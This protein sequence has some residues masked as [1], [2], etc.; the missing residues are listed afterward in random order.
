MSNLFYSRPCHLSPHSSA[1]HY[2]LGST[3]SFPSPNPPRPRP[4]HLEVP[5]YG[6]WWT[7]EAMGRVSSL[8]QAPIILAVSKP[9]KTILLRLLCGMMASLIRCLSGLLPGFRWFPAEHCRRVDQSYSIFDGEIVMNLI[10]E[11]SQYSKW[12][13]AWSSSYVV[14]DYHLFHAIV[15][16]QVSQEKAINTCNTIV[17]S[18]PIETEFIT[19]IETLIRRHPRRVLPVSLS[20]LGLGRWR[21]CPP[22]IPVGP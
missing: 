8:A 12:K 20:L 4:P 22:C 1:L 13:S 16:L 17:V 14:C 2:L 5:R 6:S 9:C 11:H 21:A 19:N 3:W 18:T 15:I 10:V 7:N